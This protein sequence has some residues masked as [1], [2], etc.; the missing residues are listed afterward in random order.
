MLCSENSQF[1]HVALFD[2]VVSHLFYWRDFDLLVSCCAVTL[3]LLYNI[4]STVY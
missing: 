4:N 3:Q 2:E 1:F